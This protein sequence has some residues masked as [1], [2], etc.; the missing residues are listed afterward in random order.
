METDLG[1]LFAVC[2]RTPV[3]SAGWKVHQHP[4]VCGSCQAALEPDTISSLLNS[5]PGDDLI[6]LANREGSDHPLLEIHR[7]GTAAVSARE[8]EEYCLT[9]GATGILSTTR[10]WSCG[11]LDHQ[12]QEAWCQTGL[13]RQTWNVVWRIIEY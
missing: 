8:A 1:L 12:R 6:L 7:S 13:R 9:Q 5:S 11:R 2:R 4:C 3:R 10:L